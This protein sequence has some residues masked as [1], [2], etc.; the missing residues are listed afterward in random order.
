[1]QT[2]LSSAQ[3]AAVSAR[4][5]A[6]M[7]T[8]MDKV[9]SLEAENAEL[10]AKLAMLTRDQEISKLA[11]EMEDKGLNADMTFEEKVASLRGH[12]HLENV[13]EAVKMATAGGV[14]IA[15]VSDHPGTGVLDPF[16]TFCLVGE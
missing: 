3:L 10:H 9:A 6:T 12:E 1:M 2:K 14:Q 4:G 11:K 7:R 15:D 16:T 5:A 8:L 13:R